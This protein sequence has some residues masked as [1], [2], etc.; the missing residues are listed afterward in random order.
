MLGAHLV[1]ILAYPLS[2]AYDRVYARNPFATL[3]RTH[4]CAYPQ[5]PARSTCTRPDTHPFATRRVPQPAATGTVEAVGENAKGTF[6]EGDRVCA[7]IGGGGYADYITVPARH[8]IHVPNAVSTVDAAA[9][10]MFSH[11]QT[12]L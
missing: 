7:L 2:R 9:I 8:A 12:S 4:V 1:H 3:S 11:P 6:A 5:A 10:R